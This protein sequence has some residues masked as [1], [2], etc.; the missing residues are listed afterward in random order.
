VGREK[1]ANFTKKWST[2]K[3]A[4]RLP[5]ID[6]PSA[7]RVKLLGKTGQLMLLGKRRD[8]S[9]PGQIQHHRLT[10]C[11]SSVDLNRVGKWLCS[12]RR[13]MRPLGADP[14]PSP[15][16]MQLFGGPEQSLE[17]AMFEEAGFGPLCAYAAPS[18]SR[19]Q[20]FG[21]HEFTLKKWLRSK[22]R[23][24]GL[25]VQTQHHRLPVSNCWL[26]QVN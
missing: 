15:A 4:L 21:E 10:T 8:S 1:I 9:L 7:A 24:S 2:P 23:D 14:A 13:G 5:V 22:R 19:A 26:K 6:A 3:G 16:S 12:K 25:S 17:M 11:N 20:L 18:P